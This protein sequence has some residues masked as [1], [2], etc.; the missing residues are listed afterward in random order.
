MSHPNPDDDV[1]AGASAATLVPRL[2]DERPGTTAPTAFEE[3]YIP[4]ISE[5]CEKMNPNDK[6]TLQYF[7]WVAL[8]EA[9]AWTE[10]LRSI[11]NDLF[12]KAGESNA[13]RTSPALQRLGWFIRNVRIHIILDELSA[14]AIAE[15]TRILQGHDASGAA[16]RLR[17]KTLYDEMKF[18]ARTRALRDV[19]SGTIGGFRILRWPGAGCTAGS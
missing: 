10:G 7:Q 6:G 4:I 17:K 13:A 5:F 11:D 8:Q 14:E 9:Y 18:A 3:Q 16:A 15:A 12:E 2:Y 19:P 1:P